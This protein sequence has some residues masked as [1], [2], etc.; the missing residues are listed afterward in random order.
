MLEKIDSAVMYRK[1]GQPGETFFVYL[2]GPFG[3]IYATYEG[4]SGTEPVHPECPLWPNQTDAAGLESAKALI[5]KWLGLDLGEETKSVGLSSPP[6][7]P[8]SYASLLRR[9]VR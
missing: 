2:L 9:E 7:L 8:R 4:E 3:F 6:A 5:K 1:C